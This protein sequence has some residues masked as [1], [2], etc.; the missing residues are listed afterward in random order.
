M[1]QRILF[2][3]SVISVLAC[4]QH[5]ADNYHRIAAFL[6]GRSDSGQHGIARFVR[7]HGE[8]K[9]QR[10]YPAANSDLQALL[11]RISTG[12]AA[13]GALVDLTDEQLDT[14]PPASD[15]KFCDGQRTLEQIVTNLL[16]HQSHQLD[17]LYAAIA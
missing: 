9:H 3:V 13:L 4:A 10:D 8:G 2:L 1:K 16:N 11:D 17:A 7:G 14:V 12:S 6:Q 5:T 15:M